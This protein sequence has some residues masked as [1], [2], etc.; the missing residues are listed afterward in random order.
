[1]TEP[2]VNVIVS[3]ADV[4]YELEVNEVEY[5]LLERLDRMT[6]QLLWVREL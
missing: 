5:A 2:T 4:E 3:I 6:G 1:M